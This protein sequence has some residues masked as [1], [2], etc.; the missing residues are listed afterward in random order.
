MP[1]L[2][3]RVQVAQASADALSEAL[4]EEGAQSVSIDALEEAQA[5]VSAT[6]APGVDCARMLAR[7]AA[8]CGA[9]IGQPWSVQP[10]EDADWVR[11]SQAQFSPLQV[12]RLW[13]GATWHEAPPGCACV[14]IDP[15]LAFGTGSHASTRL[16]LGF[17]EQAMQGGETVLDYGCG[18]GILAIAAAKLGAARVAAVDIDPLALDVARANARA[19]AADVEVHA[20]EALPRA[21]YDLVVANILARPLIERASELAA[22]TKRGGRVALAGLLASQ[23][24]EVCRAYAPAFDIALGGREDEWI[25]LVGGRR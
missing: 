2:A 21:G 22:R 20:P 15:G 24:D 18:S 16:V 7:A 9:H 5:W 4:L 8:Q 19:N 12:G 25:L 3:L 23:R 13:I 10:I 17:L 6:F 14:R 1:W 11:R